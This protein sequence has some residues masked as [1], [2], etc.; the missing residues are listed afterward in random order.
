MDVMVV[1]I[2]IVLLVHQIISHINQIVWKLAQMARILIAQV[3]LVLVVILHVNNVM[4]EVIM[5]VLY[6]LSL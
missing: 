4:E 6:V 5:I 3:I 2:K 1:L